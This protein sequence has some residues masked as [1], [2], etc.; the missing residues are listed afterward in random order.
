MCIDW[1]VSAMPQ[2]DFASDRGDFNSAIA[3]FLDGSNASPRSGYLFFERPNICNHQS[4]ADVQKQ[5]GGSACFPLNDDHTGFGLRARSFLV[6]TPEM[7]GRAVHLGLFCDDACSLTVHDGTGQAHPVVLRPPA[8][9]VPAWRSTNT[10]F[11]P[12]PGLYPIELLYVQITE[13]ANIEL[14]MMVEGVD[15]GPF[16]DVE[17]P[18]ETP[19]NPDLPAA[20]FKILG[21]NRL[22]LSVDGQWSV[23]KDQCS[24]CGRNQAD[25]PG[26][27]DCG[28]GSGLYCNAAALCAPC[29]SALRCG[30][31]CVACP[32]GW[33]CDPAAGACRPPE[34]GGGPGCS[35][36]A[37][38][39]KPLGAW[40]IGLM[41]S[42]V[43]IV[44]LRRHGRRGR[45]AS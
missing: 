2:R 6:V 44:L 28:E 14:S 25:S 19:A 20:G 39:A 1:K 33:G 21:F 3:T 4:M 8:L 32:S 38:R 17:A 41:L 15:G 31:Q 24:Q 10:V 12:A 18:V 22:L 37:A 11:F 42:G 26:N 36:G 5:F 43:G 29:T 40:A 23:E 16:C 7:I 9:G 45:G 30:P 34:K 27:G 35:V 13:R